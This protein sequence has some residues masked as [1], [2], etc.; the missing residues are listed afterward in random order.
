MALLDCAVF[1]VAGNKGG[2]DKPISLFGFFMAA[3]DRTSR[4]DIW[5]LLILIAI[6]AVAIVVML[7]LPSF[8]TGLLCSGLAVGLSMLVLS[9]DRFGCTNCTPAKKHGPEP[10]GGGSSN[11]EQLTQPLLLSPYLP[12]SSQESLP[13]ITSPEAGRAPESSVRPLPV[14][15]PLAI[16]RVRVQEPFVKLP[17]GANTEVELALQ[18]QTA[19]KD[20]FSAVPSLLQEGA[21]FSSATV[22]VPAAPT[23]VSDMDQDLVDDP[24]RGDGYRPPE[25]PAEVQARLGMLPP[26]MREAALQKPMLQPRLTEH[27]DFYHRKRR[28]YSQHWLLTKEMQEDP[29]KIWA[30]T[31]GGFTQLQNLAAQH[32]VLRRDP[33]LLEPPGYVRDGM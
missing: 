33:N 12:E 21:S 14:Q 31:G 25:N 13:D 27:S 22:P 10:I 8:L 16:P 28:Q 32:T 11:M 15:H 7:L 23:A 1:L 2:E 24:V 17:E 9:S 6:W 29:W 5:R 20:T 30:R 4:M 19:T 26:G 3:D 18:Q